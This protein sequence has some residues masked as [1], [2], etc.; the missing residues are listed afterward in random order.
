MASGTPAC[1]MFSSV[2]QDT[3]F[4]ETVVCISPGKF[5]SSNVSVCR[6]AFVRNQ[7]EILRRRSGWA[8]LKF[9]NDIL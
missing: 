5:G 6:D 8:V 4:K 7:L 1:T 2:P 3:C 9:V